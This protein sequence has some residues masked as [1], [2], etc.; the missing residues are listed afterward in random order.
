MRCDEG[1]SFE[2][3]VSPTLLLQE[4]ERLETLIE[5]TTN[6]FREETTATP[7]S[8]GSARWGCCYP[9]L[10]GMERWKPLLTLIETSLYR[11]VLL[12][13]LG[14]TSSAEEIVPA[15]TP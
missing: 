3:T 11:L 13:S 10:P 2:E 12:L 8:S 9:E 14:S 6:A 1:A 5:R 7:L 4:T 15:A